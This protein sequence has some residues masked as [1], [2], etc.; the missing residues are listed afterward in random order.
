M[1]IFVG[2]G[3]SSFRRSSG[4]SGFCDG[5]GNGWDDIVK[6]I[7]ERWGG[8]VALVWDNAPAHKG[9]MKEIPKEVAVI[10]LPPY[11]PELNFMER[12]FTDFHLPCPMPCS[13]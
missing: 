7:E 5:W 10:W 8:K 2:R 6:G 3:E 13:R 4:L 12:L 11:S 1:G 9:A